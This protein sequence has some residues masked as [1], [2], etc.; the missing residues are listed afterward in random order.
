[1]KYEKSKVVMLPTEKASELTIFKSKYG[2]FRGSLI[3]IKDFN[4]GDKSFQPQHLYFLSDEEIKEGDWVLVGKT[5]MQASEPYRL[6]EVKK[7][8]ATTDSSLT[9]DYYDAAYNELNKQSLP[10]PSNEFLKKY[11]K[12]GG[13]DEVLVAYINHEEETGEIAHSDAE[14]EYYLKVAP[15]NTITI[16][17]IKDSWSREEVIHLLNRAFSYS[18]SFGMSRDKEQTDKWIKENL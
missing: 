8:I 4:R 18:R 3:D 7:I 14:L 16:K 17:P 10:R 2:L 5:V 12:L 9:V 11:C 13:I 6:E 1:M 15:D